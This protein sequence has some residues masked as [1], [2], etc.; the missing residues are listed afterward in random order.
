MV[1][2]MEPKW[3]STVGRKKKK[4]SLKIGLHKHLS[5]YKMR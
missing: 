1:L 4:K 5:I 2:A 3:V